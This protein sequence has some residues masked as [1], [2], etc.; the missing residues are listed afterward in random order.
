VNHSLVHIALRVPDLEASVEHAQAVLGVETV[1]R[2]PDVVRLSLPGGP[3]CLILIADDRAALDHIALLTSAA[4]LARV[5]E[6]A[7][8]CDLQLHDN[9]EL[10]A[11]GIRLHAPNGL[12][13]ELAV[14]APT[15]RNA[16]ARTLGPLIGSLDHVSLNARELDATV[17][18]FVD[19]LGFRLVDSVEDKRHWLGCGPNHHTVAVFEGEDTLHHYAFETADIGELQRLGD[20]LAIRQENFVWG[21]G[22]HNLGANLFTYQLD[23]AGA[24]LE[25]CSDMIQ[26]HHEEAWQAQVWPAAGLTSAVMWGPP[27]PANFRGLAIP[28]YRHEGIDS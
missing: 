15:A 2:A 25:V 24:L 19:V 1:N 26:V 28:I 21:P 20:L 12:A 27:P 18:F 10:D 17:A 13:I 11:R 16:S 9:R 4:N 7:R 5:S 8:S 3:P 14:G 6:R 22:R 23:P